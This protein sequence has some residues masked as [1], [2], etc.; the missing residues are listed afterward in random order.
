MGGGGQVIPG[1]CF[2]ASTS[3]SPRDWSPGGSRPLCVASTVSSHAPNLSACQ[4][5][6]FKVPLQGH[7]VSL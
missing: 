4:V 5:P 3:P 1:I 7:S 6:F 2:R